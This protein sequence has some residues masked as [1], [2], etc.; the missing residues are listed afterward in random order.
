MS[1]PILTK[2]GK[3]VASRNGEFYVISSTYSTPAFNRTGL[4]SWEKIDVDIDELMGKPRRFFDTLLSIVETKR[5]ND[6]HYGGNKGNA[7]E[8]WDTLVRGCE[9]WLS[10]VENGLME[11]V[12]KLAEPIDD[13]AKKLKKETPHA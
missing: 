9:L 5:A 8:Y 3:Y 13:E 4:D 1:K 7:T 10:A 6:P 2:D 11:E 12:I